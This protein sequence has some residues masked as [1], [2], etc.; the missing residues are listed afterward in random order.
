MKK[1]ELKKTRNEEM[2][3]LRKKVAELKKEIS[4]KYAERLAGKVSN[5]KEVA[6]IKREVAQIMTI[7]REKEIIEEV[8]SSQAKKGEEAKTE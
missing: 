6:N 7:I 1:N 2:E 4:V 5:P 8:K 3:A